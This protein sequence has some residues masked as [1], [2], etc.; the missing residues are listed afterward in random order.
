MRSCSAH[1]GAYE[2]GA[3]HEFDQSFQENQTQPEIGGYAIRDLWHRAGRR[4]PDIQARH[5]GVGE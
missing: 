1:D 3:N 4:L 5:S 2:A